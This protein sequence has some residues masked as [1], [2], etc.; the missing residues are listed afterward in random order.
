MLELPEEKAK[1]FLLANKY[2]ESQAKHARWKLL[3]RTV[4]FTVFILILLISLF[5]TDDKTRKFKIPHVALID[6]KGLI[7]EE[8]KANADAFAASLRHIENSPGAKAVLI[9]INSPGG[10]PVQASYMY[11]SIQKFRQHHPK[12]KVYAVCSEACASA[13]YYIAA[14]AENIYADKSSLVG[15]IGVLYQGFGF[16]DTLHKLGVERRLIT[17]GKNK[18]FMDPFTP[19]TDEQKSKFRKILHIVHQEFKN[20]VIAGRGKR[21]KIN[22]DT[23]SGIFWTGAQ[24][25]TLGL[26]DGFASPG[27]VVRD[28]LKQKRIINYSKKDNYF[29]QLMKKFGDQIGNKINFALTSP[30]LKLG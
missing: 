29:E 17:A 16:V 13:A 25:K 18:G 6:I 5:N 4:A 14:A 10:S 28:I 8:Q 1:F 20:K 19:I 3:F 30:S 11:N 2:L 12:T 9:R 27:T 21:L 15:S 26:I 23:F 7:S 22:D 24:A